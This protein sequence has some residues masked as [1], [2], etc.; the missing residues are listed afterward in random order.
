M[1]EPCPNPAHFQARLF[2][3]TPNGQA[4]P[5][6]SPHC[7]GQGQP[8]LGSAGE[9][10]VTLTAQLVTLTGPLCKGEPTSQKHMGDFETVMQ[11]KLWL[12]PRDTEG[13]KRGPPSCV[14]VR[15]SWS[16]VAAAVTGSDRSQRHEDEGTSTGTARSRLPGKSRW[17][18]CCLPEHSRTSPALGLWVCLQT[19]AAPQEGDHPCGLSP[20]VLGPA[21]VRG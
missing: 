3:G 6:L 10:T 1:S 2:Q 21:E 17:G 12:S 19:D 5:G 9:F 14:C 7:W 8:G 15:G 16:G 4:G 11:N 13:E 18:L 20:H